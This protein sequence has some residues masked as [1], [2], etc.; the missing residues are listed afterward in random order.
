MFFF[1]FGN[2]KIL[3]TCLE[4]VVIFVFCVF[5]VLKRPLFK[6]QKKG[7]FDCFSLFSEQLL[8]M[9]SFFFSCFLCFR[10]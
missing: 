3:K 9:F 5:H 4:K 7:V 8:S 10:R 2:K 6:E 1:V